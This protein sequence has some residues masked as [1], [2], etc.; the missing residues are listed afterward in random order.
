[1]W[2]GLSYSSRIS[3][4]R[5]KDYSGL[6]A[7]G[8][9][10][11]VPESDAIGL[12]YVV[13]PGLTLAVDGQRIRYSAVPAVGNP[14]ANLFAGNPLGSAN[15][16]GFGW[17]DVTVVKFGAQYVASATWTVRVGYS[18]SGQPIPANQTF[19]NILAPAVIQSHIAIGATWKNSASG[20]LSFAYTDAIKGSVNG[21][22]SIPAPFGGGNAHI[23]L[24]ENILSV[25]YGWKL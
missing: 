5:F 3:T 4:S 10:F 24:G 20:E 9:S 22:Q 2:A 13:T 15:G 23:S 11:H 18:H 1:M 6:F 17:Q 19:F 7:Q 16:P 21:S 12:S 14:L 25:A 8:G